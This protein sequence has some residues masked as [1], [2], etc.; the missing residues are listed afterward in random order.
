M[1]SGHIPSNSE[2]VTVQSDGESIVIN[3]P[4]DFTNP[5]TS[6]HVQYKFQYDLFIGGEYIISQENEEEIARIGRELAEMLEKKFPEP[7]S[8]SVE[9]LSEE[10]FKNGTASARWGWEYDNNHPASSRFQLMM[11]QTGDESNIIII[12]VS[13][14]ATLPDHI[15]DDLIEKGHLPPDFNQDN[16]RLQ[17]E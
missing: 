15:V 8:I 11:P 4:V 13:A 10:S 1:E 3:T 17:P 14:P 16:F 12:K 7:D 5:N 6:A 9:G 2:D